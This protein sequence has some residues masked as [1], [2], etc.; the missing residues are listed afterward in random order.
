MELLNGYEDSMSESALSKRSVAYCAG[1]KAE[2]GAK[3][4]TTWEY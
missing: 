2:A 4:K 3:E 1:Q